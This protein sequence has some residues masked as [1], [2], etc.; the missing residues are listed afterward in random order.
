MYANGAEG[1][2]RL[3]NAIR[4]RGWRERHTRACGSEPRLIIVNRPDVPDVGALK[5]CPGALVVGGAFHAPVVREAAMAYL[6]EANAHDRQ[7]EAPPVVR[8]PVQLIADLL[9]L[10]WEGVVGKDHH[11]TV[12][13]SA[14]A[15]R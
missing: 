12:A 1:A 5:G 4:M 2:R 7:H 13:S 6:R 8:G 10:P 11:R 9:Q 3:D 15:V 14:G